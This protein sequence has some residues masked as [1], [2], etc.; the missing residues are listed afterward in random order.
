MASIAEVLHRAADRHLSGDDDYSK[1]KSELSCIAVRK[2]D[3][4]GPDSLRAVRGLE[5]MG[6][7]SWLTANFDEFPP[8]P[9]RQAVRYAWLKFAALIAEEQGV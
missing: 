6:L 8:G 1:R 9:E 3:G 5:K 7:G 2:A 4:W